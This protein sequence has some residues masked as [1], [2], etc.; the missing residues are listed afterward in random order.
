[1]FVSHS[2]DIFTVVPE[3]MEIT[4]KNC[5]A[6]ASGKY[7]AECGQKTSTSRFTVKHFVHEFTH[8]FTHADT[9][10]LYMAKELLIRP[11]TVAREFVEGKR[12]RYFSPFAFLLILL[13]LYVLGV[14]KTG[15]SDAVVESMQNLMEKAKMNTAAAQKDIEGLRQMSKVNDYNKPLALAL[16]PLTSL[17]TLALFRKS[18][19]N[20]AEHLVF[21][22][23]TSIIIYL[24]FLLFAF[25]PFLVLPSWVLLFTYLYV[26]INT[27][28]AFRAYKG[29]F[30]ESWFATIWKGI[31]VQVALY[32]IT[33]Q[34]TGLIIN[35]VP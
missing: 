19:Y 21:N 29:F 25:L 11:G 10:V 5:G 35:M 34:L 24:L 18:K 16:I 20:Y 3:P 22:V 23:F 12:K 32:I 8:A 4:C 1:L 6:S 26:A 9:G 28:Y 33:A 14:S 7:C 13:S 17:I 2:T 27:V 15:Y 31:I 30:Q